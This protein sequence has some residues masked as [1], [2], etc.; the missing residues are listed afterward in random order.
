MGQLAF[1]HEDILFT[2]GGLI[3]GPWEHSSDPSHSHHTCYGYVPGREDQPRFEDAAEWVVALNGWKQ[4]QLAEWVR[5]PFWSAAGA[6]G[7]KP[8]VQ[9]AGDV[10][11]RGGQGPGGAR[12]Q[13]TGD[14]PTRGGS[15]LIDYVAP[16]CKPSVVMGRHLDKRGMPQP[17]PQPL[18]RKLRQS[19]IRKVVCPSPWPLV[20]WRLTYSLRWPSA[21]R[22]MA[23]RQP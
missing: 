2:H 18:L 22:P 15:E 4:A 1:I 16:G 10:P 9:G 6:A 5:S 8:T 3:G 17:M 12:G 11:T 23:T 7:D 20:S 19:G 14:V 13:G 21:T